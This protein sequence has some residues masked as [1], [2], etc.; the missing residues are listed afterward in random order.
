MSKSLLLKMLFIAATLVNLVTVGMLLIPVSLSF[1]SDKP[2]IIIEPPSIKDPTIAPGSTFTI[3]VKLYN[4]TAQN[5]PAGVQG[6]EVHL[7]WNNTLIEPTSFTNMIGQT[8]GVLNP[9]ILYGIDPGF[10]DE[11]GNKITNP[12]YTNAKYYKVA[13][14]STGSPW[15]GDGVIAT[16]TFKAISVGKC[17]LSF[18]YTDLVDANI[19]S[20]SHYVKGGCF[21]NRPTVP[22]A[23]VY[24]NPEKIVDPTLSPSSTFTIN[25]RIKN[26]QYLSKFSFNMSFNPVVLEIMLADWAWPASPPDID[27]VAGVVKGSITI[28]PPFSGET[29]L[30]TIQCHVKDV[31]ESSFHLYGLQL[32]D[33]CNESIPFTTKD[34]YFNNMLVTKIFID[35]PYRMDPNLRPGDLTVFNVNGEN[36]IDIGTIEFY[37]LYN[38]N[39]IKIIGYSITPIPGCLID[40]EIAINN[41][42]GKMYAYINYSPSMSLSR[43]TIMNVTFQVVGF[44]VS[45]IDLNNTK[46]LDYFG[47]MVTHETEDGL[48][49]TVIRDIAVVG[50]LPVP[51]KVYPGRT[52]TIYV[53]VC[54]LGNISESFTVTAYVDGNLLG[55]ATVTNLPPASNETMSFTW[56]TDGLPWCVWHSLS[57][58]VTIIP[59]EFDVGNNCL[60][61]AQGVKIKKFGDING[62]GNVDLTD[63]TLFAKSYRKGVGDP[64]YNPDADIDGNGFVSLADLVTIARYYR[65]SC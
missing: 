44:G 40:S 23:Q 62:D 39:V 31:G 27:N 45:P 14:A 4:V 3:T 51:Q 22:T 18:T 9:S 12:P 36:F 52:V 19:V 24:I 54:N 26:V 29:T 65:T 8:G 21:D 11:A 48:L 35:P 30:L 60:E 63:L 42:L 17:A 20:I 57:A 49:V 33:I 32:L 5:V 58:N 56:N 64:L 43:G 28:I 10:Y 46:L 61:L 34:G 1:P 41:R 37:L 47:N 16:I 15:W 13:A 53:T 59:Y 2:A 50:I 38:P 25:M 6:V 55:T 7:T